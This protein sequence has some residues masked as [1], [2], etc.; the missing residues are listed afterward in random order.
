MGKITARNGIK[1]FTFVFLLV[2]FA[3]VFSLTTH[4]QEGF[5]VRAWGSCQKNAKCDAINKDLLICP[6]DT[7]T[8]YLRVMVTD[9]DDGS[10][11]GGNC[12][13]APCSN[14]IVI[15]LGASY[16]VNGIWWRMHDHEESLKYSA[17]IS[18]DGNSWAIVSEGDVTTTRSGCRENCSDDHKNRQHP[19]G[20]QG[21]PDTPPAPP[22]CDC[23]HPDCNDSKC[24]D[25][26]RRNSWDCA[27]SFAE[28]RANFAQQPVRYLRIHFRNQDRHAHIYDVVIPRCI[29]WRDCD[30]TCDTT[31]NVCASPYQC[32]FVGIYAGYRCRNPDCISEPSCVC[33]T[34]TPTP[35]TNYPVCMYLRPADEGGT[36]L[37]LDEV[38][39]SPGDRLYFYCHA[40]PSQ[41]FPHHYNFRYKVDDQP[42]DNF[43]MGV[44]SIF[45]D[46][47]T[48]R[49]EFVIP[50]YGDYTA[51]CQICITI[52]DSLCTE[53]G[54]AHIEP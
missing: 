13:G 7:W 30:E 3:G 49:T 47:F 44:P 5:E 51:Q 20:D 1:I 21:C 33:P 37:T 29:Q 19:P 4:R 11:G 9:D 22:S 46:P 38:D 52:D 45:G 48:S 50:D 27:V 24:T 6:D 35:P 26:E 34:P 15:D 25:W 23:A 53:W 2:A 17:S 43:A 36:Y 40:D 12:G 8:E 18:N 39:F 32:E 41:G 54:K 14:E 31:Y 42:W 10:V 28:Y 16:E